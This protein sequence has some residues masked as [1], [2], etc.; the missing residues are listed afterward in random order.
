[1]QDGAREIERKLGLEDREVALLSSL[2]LPAIN[3]A[4]GTRSVPLFIDCY[5]VVKRLRP[6]LVGE[7]LDS[8]EGERNSMKAAV[9]H[10]PFDVRIEEV[11]EPG[12]PGPD[13]VLLAPLVGSLC[14][15]DVTEFVTGPKR[16][17][18]HHVH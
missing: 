17:P 1:R 14:G 7:R 9:Y 10:G 4:A 8:Q 3:R 16:I 6:C 2:T 15:T 12:P 18:L 5:V 13:E 11:P